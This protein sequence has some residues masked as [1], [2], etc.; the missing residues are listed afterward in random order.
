MG[1]YYSYLPSYVFQEGSRYQQ[2]NQTYQRLFEKFLIDENSLTKAENEK[3]WQGIFHC[4]EYVFGSFRFMIYNNYDT[5]TAQ[6]KIS[7]AIFYRLCGC[8]GDDY[9]AELEGPLRELSEKA[10][11]CSLNM[12]QH[13]N[14]KRFVWHSSS[15]YR[16]LLKHAIEVVFKSLV[17][18]YLK[19]QVIALDQRI[20]LD[21]LNEY[22][23]GQN[24]H[25]SGMDIIK[26]AGI[27]KQIPAQMLA[28]LLDFLDNGET[29]DEAILM[30]YLKIIY[31]KLSH[32][33]K[34]L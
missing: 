23:A 11:F 10:M 18:E 24:D 26:Q 28:K 6:D 30:P 9:E 21:D 15:K 5:K 19:T 20:E 22:D 4:A 32:S 7:T 3:F 2:L 14:N 33:Q 8:Y 31:Q 34:E 25:L 12:E 27:E 1:S 29:K 17:F 16:T 13:G